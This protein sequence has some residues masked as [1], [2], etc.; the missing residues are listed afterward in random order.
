MEEARAYLM[1]CLEKQGDYDFLP[2]GMLQEMLQKL[3]ELDEAYMKE[4]G[5]EQGAPYDDD[6]ALEA[7]HKGMATAFPQHAMYMRKLSEDY[8]D[9]NEEYLESIGAIDWS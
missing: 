7:L 8:L 9:Y 4:S 1:E 5:V 6:D 2:E 3:M